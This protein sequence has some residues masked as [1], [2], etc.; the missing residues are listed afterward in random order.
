MTERRR[1]VHTAFL[2]LLPI[3]VAAFGW[4][5]WTA[6][7]TVLLMLLWR[8]TITMS[9]F[10]APEKHPPLVLDSISASHFVEKVRWNMDRAGIEYVERPAGGTLGAYFLGRTVPRL[11]IRTGA[12]RSQIGNSAEI[13]RYL[14][15]AYVTT[16]G[17]SVS[18]LE[19]TPERLALEHRLD[20]YGVNLQ[21]WVYH[22]LLEDRELTLHAWGTDNP[23]VPLWQR[24]LLRPLYPVLATLIRRSFRITVPNYDKACGHIE[25]LLADM[26]ATLSDGRASILG[27]DRPNYTDFQF[28]AMSGLWLQPRNYGGGQADKVR[29]ERSQATN[30][31]RADIERWTENYPKA[32]AWV[33]ALYAE[34]RPCNRPTNA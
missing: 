26:D 8:W 24:L 30:P 5:V 31:M 27:G 25:A 16:P 11:W 34:E 4:S 23:A 18:H 9:G 14:W 1:L 7:L 21:V 13:L 10:I 19:P 3:L 22:H 29:I 6:V 33:Q 20:R 15:G 12:V 2:F 17:A 28:A 32:V